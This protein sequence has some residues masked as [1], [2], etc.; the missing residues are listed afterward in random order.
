MVTAGEPYYTQG[1]TSYAQC[2]FPNAQ[3]PTSAF[4]P[5]ATNLLKYILPANGAIDP[6]SGTGVYTTNSGKQNLT[7]N[8][9]SGRLDANTGFGL[10]SGYYYFDRYDRVDPYWASNAPLYPGFSADG[11]GQTHT[12]DL[13]DTK[14]FG[15]SVNEFRLGYY[16]LNARFNLPLGG[17][18]SSLSSLGFASGASGAPGIF[19]GSPSLVGIPEIDFNN[20]AIGVPS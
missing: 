13:G 16:R 2:V 18:V 4:S 19:T 10:L 17:K 6:T 11:K 15:A 5:I 9:F 7:D 1:C 3:L 12:I 8:K 20:F 14:T